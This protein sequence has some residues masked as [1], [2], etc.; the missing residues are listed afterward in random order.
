M[1]FRNGARMLT[2]HSK[3]VP[4]LQQTKKSFCFEQ[5][6][7]INSNSAQW[8]DTKQWRRG[9]LTMPVSADRCCDWKNTAWFSGHF[10]QGL[11]V[12]GS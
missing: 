11:F 4:Q 3:M 8:R 5:R 12:L 10:G 6:A 7:S 2:S 1:K 9:P